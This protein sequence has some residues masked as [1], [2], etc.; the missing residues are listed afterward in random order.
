VRPDD[1]VVDANTTLASSGNDSVTSPS[2]KSF[3]DTVEALALQESVIGGLFCSVNVF[4]QKIFSIGKKGLKPASAD[5]IAKVLAATRQRMQQSGHLA[6]S[7]LLEFQ[8]GCLLCFNVGTS[9]Q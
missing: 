2:F 8:V 7:F 3:T 1:I 5:E 6:V 9:F 4:V